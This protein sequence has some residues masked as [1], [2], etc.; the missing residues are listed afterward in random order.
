M[1][2]G[3]LSACAEFDRKELYGVTTCGDDW[4]RLCIK[5]FFQFISCLPCRQGQADETAKA[6]AVL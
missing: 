1:I 5:T 6:A 4:E 2:L 3:C